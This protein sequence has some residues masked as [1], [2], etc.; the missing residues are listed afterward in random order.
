VRSEQ[1]G[2]S[3][4]ESGV[5]MHVIAAFFGPCTPDALPS[6]VSVFSHD[7]KRFERFANLATSSWIK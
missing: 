7:F 1:W 5:G 3:M 2:Y 4:A 6:H